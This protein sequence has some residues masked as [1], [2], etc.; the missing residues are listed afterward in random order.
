MGLTLESS[1][2]SFLCVG[3]T[4][5]VFEALGLIFQIPSFIKANPT[6]D[7]VGR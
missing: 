5:S 3:T 1:P 4:I 2:P 6:F 7:F